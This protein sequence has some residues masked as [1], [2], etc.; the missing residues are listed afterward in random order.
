M[1]FSVAF[2]LCFTVS[3]QQ[4][5]PQDPQKLKSPYKERH[6]CARTEFANRNHQVP[7]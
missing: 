7:E 1:Q 4:S 5:Q 6:H 2:L 3:R